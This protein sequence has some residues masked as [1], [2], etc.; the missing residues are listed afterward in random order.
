MIWAIDFEE[1][2]SLCLSDIIAVIRN[3]QGAG[4]SSIA[5]SSGLN[6]RR[7]RSMSN[8]TRYAVDPRSLQ[9]CRIR[10]KFHYQELLQETDPIVRANVARALAEAAMDLAQVEGTIVP[11]S[12]A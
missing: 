3:Q 1:C 9:G 5:L 7:N 12:A 2:W 6:Y 8:S 4:M 11:S 10:L